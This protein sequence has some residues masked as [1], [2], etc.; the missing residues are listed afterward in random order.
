MIVFILISQ[1]PLRHSPKAEC[2]LFLHTELHSRLTAP[3]QVRHCPASKMSL[4]NILSQLPSWLL[5]HCHPL[6][7]SPERFI[8]HRGLWLQEH[9][10]TNTCHLWKRNIFRVSSHHPLEPIVRELGLALPAE[11][12]EL[13]P[14]SPAF[15]WQVVRWN[16]CHVTHVSKGWWP[17]CSSPTTC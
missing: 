15:S 13:E 1:A 7:L 5:W 14:C 2:R 4:G 16:V 9:L 17:I 10:Q 8:L 11:A 3:C 6:C 12:R